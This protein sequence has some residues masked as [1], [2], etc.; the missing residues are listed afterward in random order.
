MNQAGVLI[1][2]ML[3]L[4]ETVALWRLRAAVRGGPGWRSG[5]PGD[6]FRFPRWAVIALCIGGIV[7]WPIIVGVG[8]L[9]MTR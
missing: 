9:V 5:R 7:G 4:W 1:I 6:L 3:I 8:W 2:M